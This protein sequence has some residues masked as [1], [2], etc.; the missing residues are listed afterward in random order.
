[1]T[2]SSRQ[3]RWFHFQQ[4]FGV[5]TVSEHLRRNNLWGLFWNL[6]DFSRL[7]FSRNGRISTSFGPK[8]TAPGVSLRHWCWAWVDNEDLPT[9]RWGAARPRESRRWHHNRSSCRDDWRQRRPRMRYCIWYMMIPHNT[10]IPFIKTG[11]ATYTKVLPTWRN[12]FG[13]TG[14]FKQYKYQCL[15]ETW[16][17]IMTFFSFGTFSAVSGSSKHIHRASRSAAPAG[18]STSSSTELPGWAQLYLWI[19]YIATARC[20]TTTWYGKIYVSAA[21][22]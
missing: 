13:L 16:A 18:R 19:L 21:Y 11:A 20:I 5:K 3:H 7:F 8:L 6:L 17:D 12:F 15:E 10:I 9:T 2:S 4:M 22:M 14:S 1:M